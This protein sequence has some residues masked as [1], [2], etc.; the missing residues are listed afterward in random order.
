M[1]NQEAEQRV[2]VITGA[3]SGVGR[4]TALAFAAQGMRLALAAREAGSLTEAARDCTAE[5]AVAAL[6]FPIDIADAHA[7]EMLADQ[8]VERFG[9]IDVWVEAA[10]VLIAGP[11]EA[12][13]IDEM[14]RLIDTNV[15]GTA[16]GARAAL[17]I[18]RQQGHGTLI[19]VS[20]LL[21]LVPSH[22]LPLYVMSKFATRGLALSLRQ[23]VANTPRL[24]VC[25]VMPGPV[26]T[27]MFQRAA[28]YTGQA[29][30][31]IPP[32]H[33]PERVAATIVACVR[34]PRR[35][36]TTGLTSWAILLSHRLAPRST[37]WLV[38]Q[39]SARLLTRSA[40]APDDHG[41]IREPGRNSSLS[42]G[43]RNNRL[44][45]RWG[46]RLGTR[47]ARRRA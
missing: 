25:T 47:M 7:S 9:R 23:A 39:W 12:H 38:A 4:A 35:Q 45:R 27:P 41:A 37:E 1:R 31:A 15:A 43:W 20:S 2:V 13:P 28:N 6:T 19:I 34:R 5:G 14:R 17:R 11:L 36:T 26:D 30:R 24:N 16:L 22:L 21:G 18:F 29:L 40:P 3:S 10:S 8:V 42:G 46:E 44:R 33:A 32:A